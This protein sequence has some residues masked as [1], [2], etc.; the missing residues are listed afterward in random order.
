MHYDE[1][2]STLS[3]LPTWSL[4]VLWPSACALVALGARWGML[5]SFGSDQRGLLGGV[6][7]PLM[8]ALGAAFALLAALSLA[9]EATQLRAASQD[10]SLEAASAARL[11]WAATNPG[12]DD[13]AIHDALLTYLQA[14]RASEWTGDSALGDAAAR[15]A[16]TDLERTVRAT[17]GEAEVGS[18]QAGELLGALDAVTAARRQ[19]LAAAVSHLPWLYVVVVGVSGVALIIN[20]SAL[21]LAHSRQVALLT[22]GLVIVV[23][24][25]LALLFSLSAP[26]DGAFVVSQGPIDGVIANLQDGLFRR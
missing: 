1:A 16:L 23:G 22:S 6:A 20:S 21:A 2:V 12:L 19:R 15:T 25:C 9:G 17:A 3:S 24:L 14:T 10:A 11:A 13:S 18:A 4:I 26:F 8:P 7:G 5:R